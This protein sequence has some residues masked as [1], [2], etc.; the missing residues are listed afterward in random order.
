VHLSRQLQGKVTEEAYRHIKLALPMTNRTYRILEPCCF[1][2]TSLLLRV[3]LAHETP[4]LVF[5]ATLYMS[6]NFSQ[7]DR[8]WC[9]GVFVR[10]H[11]SIM[12]HAR[13]VAHPVANTCERHRGRGSQD[14]REDNSCCRRKP[15]SSMSP[16]GESTQCAILRRCVSTPQAFC[17]ASRPMRKSRSSPME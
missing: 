9:L 14:F 16:L 8:C 4:L 15:T 3:L 6:N 12:L 17:A 5:H 7:P 11:S 1:L 2:I 13:S 10:W